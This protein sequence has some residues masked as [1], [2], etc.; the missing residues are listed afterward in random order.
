MSWITLYTFQQT[1]PGMSSPGVIIVVSRDSTNPAHLDFTNLSGGGA[2]AQPPNGTYLGTVCAPG[3]FDQYTYFVSNTGSPY[4]TFTVLHNS[5]Y[6]G[7]SPPACDIYIKTFKVTPETNSSNNNGTVNMFA[8]SSFPPITY[9]LSNVGG[10][11][12]ETNDTGFF[13]NLPPDDYILNAGDANE[14]TVFKDFTIAAFG[15]GGTN[16][17]YRLKFTDVNNV[18]NWE[19]KFLDQLNVY[20]PYVYP[21]DVT[22]S[23]P[24]PVIKTTGNQNEDKTNVIIPTVLDILLYYTGLD[25]NIDEFVTVPEQSWKIEFWLNGS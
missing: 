14:C 17:K 15:T 25:F 18:N 5:T 24:S 1:P 12:Y 23:G 11:F 19:L 6:C 10:T 21:I 16:Y 3:T 20:D 22:G 13:N 8:I 4:A 7:Y 9:S 2:P